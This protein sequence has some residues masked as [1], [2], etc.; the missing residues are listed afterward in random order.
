L[1]G[2]RQASAAGPKREVKSGAN[3]RKKSTEG[4]KTKK[5]PGSKKREKR[6][7]GWAK[8]RQRGQGKKFLGGAESRRG[9]RNELAQPKKE[10][11]N[12]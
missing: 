12:V 1:R 4:P 2:Q 6:A 10:R 7:G 8:E 11:R 9:Q 5:Q 3:E